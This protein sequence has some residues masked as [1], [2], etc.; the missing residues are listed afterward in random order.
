MVK[1][2][3]MP[4]EDLFPVAAEIGFAAVE[5]W[6]RGDDFE[7]AVTLAH[8]HNLAIAVM[9]GHASL[10]E[11]LCDRRNHD[12]IE[13]ELRLSIDVAADNNIPGLICLTG[14]RIAGQNEDEA[15][16]A[17]A[18]GLRRVAPYAEK[19]GINLNLELLNSKIDHPGYQGDHTAWGVAVCERVASERVKRLADMYPLQRREGDVIRTITENI[20]RIGHFH[21]AG[22]PGRHDF[23][24]TQ[25]LNYAA[26]AS[27]IAATDYDGYVGHEFA[28]KGDVFESLRRAFAICDKG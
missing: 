14:N 9:V 25:E 6:A 7:K 19:R 20:S 28:P 8:R 15:A 23:D 10:S 22:N 17:A 16:D 13:K 5:M 1:P 21:T 11:G 24:D 18:D 12:R 26:I 2:E 3:S 27:A 4:L